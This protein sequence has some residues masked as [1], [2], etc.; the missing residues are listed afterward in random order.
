MSFSEHLN[1]IGAGKKL[2]EWSDS[3]FRRGKGRMGLIIL[4][5]VLFLFFVTA[6]GHNHNRINP[7]GPADEDC[8][9]RSILTSVKEVLAE[10][11]LEEECSMKSP[12]GG[13]IVCFKLSFSET[14]SNSEECVPV[15][16]V[17]LQ[18]CLS[19]LNNIEAQCF[20][21]AYKQVCI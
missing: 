16:I 2:F 9:L 4:P 20:S 10:T 14:L 21:D 8:D 6:S 3:Y 17:A 5:Q 18:P 19:D 13:S 12:D 15:A 11:A 7:Y 1:R